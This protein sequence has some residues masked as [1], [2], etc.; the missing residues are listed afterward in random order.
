MVYMMFS[1]L[2]RREGLACRVVNFSRSE[3]RFL[4]AGAS[5]DGSMLYGLQ[6]D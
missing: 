1:L 3:A 6:H 5:F 4:L 2:T